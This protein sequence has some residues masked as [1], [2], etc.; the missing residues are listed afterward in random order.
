M[1]AGF[2]VVMLHEADPLA[3]GSYL[4]DPIFASTPR[5][6][7]DAGLYGSLALAWQPE[8]FRAVSAWLVA[9]QL[10]ARLHQANTLNTTRN[11]VR[12]I[13]RRVSVRPLRPSATGSQRSIGTG[14]SL[15]L[16]S[17]LRPS[18]GSSAVTELTTGEL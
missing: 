6:L 1:E 2:P 14:G 7:R 10:G 5:P 9:E 3:G 12:G 17:R 11:F 13:V 8:P 18:A 4:F 15:A 16:L